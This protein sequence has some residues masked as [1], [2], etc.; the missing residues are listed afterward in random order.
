M[1]KSD[2]K[3]LREELFLKKKLAE[4]SVDP[5]ADFT[6]T[7]TEL[8]FLKLSDF[9]AKNRFKV[10]ATLLILAVIMIAFVSIGEYI[11]STENKAMI[12]AEALERKWEKNPT[13]T[14]DEKIAQMEA[15]LNEHSSKNTKLL[16]S[17][18]L[19][20]SYLE[21]KEFAKAATYYETILSSIEE[22][23]EMKAY[24]SMIAGNARE[25]AKEFPKAG[26]H[27]SR[28]TSLLMNNREANTF[29][30]WALYSSARMKL[31]QDQKDAAKLELKKILDLEDKQTSGP[32]LND[33]KQLATYLILSIN[34]G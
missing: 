4:V 16:F 18:R 29:Y 30:A 2:K 31:L 5:Y 11:R 13:I 22:P 8:A 25:N 10:F 1:A 26:A 24:F 15:F 23:K 17:K 20:D 9:M 12:Q 14:N 28:A 33:V 32:Y 7:K 27:Y 6:G 21:K 34:K 19:G 3:K